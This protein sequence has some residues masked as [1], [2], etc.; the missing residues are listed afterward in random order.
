[1]CNKFNPH[2]V[3]VRVADAKRINRGGALLSEFGGCSG[4]DACL[5]EIRRTADA[6]D[7]HLQS[8]AYWQYKYYQD[9]TT[10]A[11]NLESLWNPDGSLQL[12]KIK[13]LSR[14]YAQAVQ[15][16]I[17][18]MQFDADT[19]A[20]SL[21]YTADAAITSPTEIYVNLAMWYPNGITYSPSDAYM[22]GT[23]LIVPVRTGATTVTI[24]SK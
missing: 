17:S 9:V 1:M 3:S 15:G 13:E 6:A 23:T 5:R 22:Q 11:T 21:S 18:A 19:G 10:Q 24:A 7:Q 14:T 2:A 8:W 4:S 12:P 20:F 16:T